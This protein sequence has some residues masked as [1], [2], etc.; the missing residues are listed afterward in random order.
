MKKIIVL[1]TI[2]LTVMVSQV[3]FA[4]QWNNRR[5]VAGA[6]REV[7]VEGIMYHHPANWTTYFDDFYSFSTADWDTNFSNI[8]SGTPDVV[9]NVADSVNGIVHIWVTDTTG[10]G[11]K[12]QMEDDIPVRFD[13]TTAS[14]WTW[15]TKLRVSDKD[16]CTIFAGFSTDGAADTSFCDSLWNDV[17]GDG[18]FF[19]K[20][21]GSDTFWGATNDAT[22][23]DSV[24]LSS[25]ELSDSTW[26]TLGID[27]YPLQN[28]VVF[29]IDDKAVGEI[30]TVAAIP[31]NVNLYMA[32]GYINRM[33]TASYIDLDYWW[34]KK[35]R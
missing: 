25:Y 20:A 10:R 14:K 26:V 33:G 15:E 29:R 35:E 28:S 12:K 21:N 31:N 13:T 16:S 9:F 34:G 24:L 17:A 5:V 18:V 11:I 23:R 3:L 4:Q 8:A 22:V 30:N 1:I 19:Y 27:Y 7:L 2:L 6:V 32:Y